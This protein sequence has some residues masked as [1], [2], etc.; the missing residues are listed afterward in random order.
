[1]PNSFSFS[2]SSSS[3]S[4]FSSSYTDPRLS[5]FY[6]L[7]QSLSSVLNRCMCHPQ[8]FRGTYSS[9]VKKK[10][11][12]EEEVETQIWLLTCVREQSSR[13]IEHDESIDW[14]AGQC[15]RGTCLLSRE[16]TAIH[17]VQGRPEAVFINTHTLFIKLHRAMLCTRIYIDEVKEARRASKALIQSASKR[18]LCAV[19]I[20]VTRY[21]IV[22]KKKIEGISPESQLFDCLRHSSVMTYTLGR[23]DVGALW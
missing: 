9:R 18:A 19:I 14:A 13:V 3:S 20:P 16:Y 2:S 4:C 21:S 5:V 15:I 23:T 22:K 11:G 7:P 17:V 1:M 8:V 6:F 12:K 10:K